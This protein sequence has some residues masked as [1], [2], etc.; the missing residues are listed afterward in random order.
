MMSTGWG[1]SLGALGPRAPRVTKGVP[2]NKEKRRERERERGGE[3]EREREPEEKKER[4][5]K[6]GRKVNQ[7]DKRGGMQFQAQT[8]VLGEKTSVVPNWPRKRKKNQ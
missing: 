8:G 2:K 4:D 3:R 1:V 5:R 6:K 7:H